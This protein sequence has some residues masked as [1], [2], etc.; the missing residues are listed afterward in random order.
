MSSAWP[1]L[2][3]N[4]AHTDKDIAVFNEAMQEIQTEQ[5]RKDAMLVWQKS[6]ERRAVGDTVGADLLIAIARL[7]HPEAGQ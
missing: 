6:E 7:I 5:R 1:F 3:G 4:F 2:V